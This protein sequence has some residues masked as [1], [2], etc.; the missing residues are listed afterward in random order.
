MAAPQNPESEIDHETPQVNPNQRES[1]Q[2][3]FVIDRENSRSRVI[4]LK[5]L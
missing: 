4:C 1:K 5:F 2:I 3:K